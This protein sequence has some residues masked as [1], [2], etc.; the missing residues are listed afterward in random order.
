MDFD[1]VRVWR[2]TCVVESVHVLNRENG[3]QEV[4]IVTAGGADG[5]AEWLKK[6]AALHDEAR[7]RMVDPDG[8]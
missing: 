1:G 2:G 3:K 7:R 8:D 6:S 4:V 5:L